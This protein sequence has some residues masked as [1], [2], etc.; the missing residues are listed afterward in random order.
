MTETSTPPAEILH[1]AVD[2]TAADVE[3][4]RA[5]L[6]QRI[7]ALL[8]QT[9]DADPMTRAL[10][11]LEALASSAVGSAEWYLEQLAAGVEPDSPLWLSRVHGLRSAWSELVSAAQQWSDE[12]GFNAYRWR[13]VETDPKRAAL[14]H[15]QEAERRAALS[16]QRTAEQA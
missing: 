5:F 7:D 11:A 9:P 15:L 12:P 14:H 1:Y 3:S 4:L 6:Y 10:R 8:I 2:I 16:S 13:E